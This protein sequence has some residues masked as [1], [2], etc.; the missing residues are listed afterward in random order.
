[1]KEK[2]AA[3]PLLSSSPLLQEMGQ[4]LCSFPASLSPCNTQPGKSP[5]DCYYMKEQ[6]DPVIAP[7][8]GLDDGEEELMVL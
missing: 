5:T 6:G 4:L 1:M 3:A 7:R 8:S 2:A